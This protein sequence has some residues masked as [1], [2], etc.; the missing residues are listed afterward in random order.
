VTPDLQ[1]VGDLSLSFQVQ[2]LHIANPYELQADLG[3]TK[4]A[5]MVVFNL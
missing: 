3:L 1:R 5:E 4:F 2:T